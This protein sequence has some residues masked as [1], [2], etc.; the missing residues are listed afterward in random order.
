MIGTRPG[1][2]S[3]LVTDKTPAGRELISSGAGSGW[4]WGSRS[5][6]HN[7]ILGSDM[8]HNDHALW[9]LGRTEADLQVAERQEVS[10]N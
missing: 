9:H 5:Y 7:T 3:S 1:L 6:I 8:G 10:F 2:G 4:R